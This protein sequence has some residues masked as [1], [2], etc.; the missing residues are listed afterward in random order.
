[1]DQGRVVPGEAKGDHRNEVLESPICEPEPPDPGEAQVG[2]QSPGPGAARYI[3][4]YPG[5]SDAQLRTS[6]IRSRRGPNMYQSHCVTGEA[7]WRPQ[8]PGSGEPH[9]LTRDTRSR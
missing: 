3:R 6:V 2:P 8:E 9:M 4:E 1:M 7:R 5:P